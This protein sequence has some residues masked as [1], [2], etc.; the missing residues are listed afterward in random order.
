MC[1]C[2][3]CPPPQVTSGGASGSDKP[4]SCVTAKLLGSDPNA[5]D[6][7]P[8]PPRVLANLHEGQMQEQQEVRPL[9]EQQQ[10]QQQRQQ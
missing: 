2:R 7:C 1:V 10:Q 9:Q 4:I 8:P 3:D 6:T 5:G